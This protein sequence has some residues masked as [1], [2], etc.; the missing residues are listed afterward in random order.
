MAAARHE[1]RDEEPTMEMT[2]TRTVPATVDATWAALNDPEALKACIPGCE[3]LERTGENELRAAMTA[4]V[5]PVSARFSG[6]IR[7]SDIVPASSY[8]IR[9]EGQG[10]AAGFANGEAHVALAAQD[11][12]TQID[13]TVKAQVGGKLAQIGSRLI[14]GAAAKIADDFFARFAERL[15]PPEAR[16]AQPPAAPPA[17]SLWIRL[18][19]A[20][21]I[22]V[23]IV[24]YWLMQSGAK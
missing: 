20:I 15:T 16:V 19:L 5:G 8:T 7:L 21:A 3:S 11:G 17:R 6:L 9:F 13:Y 1:G 18:A 14:D 12:G 24:L 2:G 4:R 10:G 22:I 23:A